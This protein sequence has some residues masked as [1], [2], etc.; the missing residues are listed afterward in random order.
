MSRSML[1]AVAVVS[2]AILAYQVLLM[3]LFSIT[4]WHHFAYMIISVA[5]LG[6]GASGTALALA[7]DRL[8]PHFRAAFVVCCVLF[9]IS[10]IGSFA[11]AVR[12]PF[13]PLAIVWDRSQLLWLG[14]SYALL[15][16][17][18][19][20][21]GSAIGL[22]FARA[23]HQLGRTYAFDLVGAG[24]GALGI[25]G[26]LF[27]LSP[28][29]ALRLVAALGFGAGALACLGARRA[30]AVALTA[31]ALLVALWLPPGLT[32][33]H[34]HVSQYKGLSMALQVPDARII[35]ERSSPLGLLTLVESPTIPFRHAPG[36]SLN[37]L[38]EPPPQL[39]LFT[40]ADSLTVITRFTGDLEPLAYL[41]FTT[42]A[43]PYHLIRE[44]ETLILGAGGGE[45][46]LLALYHGAPR[47]DAVELNPQ[48]I[49]LVAD[50]HADFAGALYT[51]PSVE[52]H[53][54][55]ARSFV[56]RTDEQFD[57]IQMPLLTSF[58]AAA[59]GTQSLH[60]S[61]AYT[62]EAMGEYLD[63]LQPGGLLAITLWLKLPPRDMPKLLAIAVEALREA[64]IEDPGARLALVRGW[65]TS[66]LLVRNGEFTPDE[67]AALR[68]FAEGRSFDLDWVPG[69]APEEA[70]RFN[71]LE[72][73]YF[74]EAALALTGP[75]SGAYI[76]RYKFNIA[77]ATDNRPYFYDFFRWRSLSELVRMGPQ[78]ASTLLDMGYLIL[79]ATL[80]QATLLSLVLILLP[81]VI[82]RRRFGG[83]A[84]KLR[85]S[86]Y[87]LALGLAFLYIEIAFIQRFALFLG[88]PLYAV[89]VVL[90][91]FLVFAG[92]GSA[93][94]GRLGRALISRRPGALGLIVLGIAL[95]ALSYLFLLGPI[96]EVLIALPDWAKIIISLGLIAPLACL[97]GM[98]FPLGLARGARESEDLLPWAWGI[99]GCAS[100][101]ASILATLLAIHFGFTA[102]VSLAVAL[103]LL[104]PLLLGRVG[105]E[106]ALALGPV[107]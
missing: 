106:P 76:E 92:L 99:N 98:P 46:V 53:V 4:G 97:M 35:E 87:F 103:Y 82:R 79:V 60:E 63:R 72:R 71:I 74:Y 57:L 31:A 28:E 89:A 41:D 18:F 24:T 86:A 64:G 10:A 55:E 3:R 95:I 30:P 47:I 81:L 73:P 48:V 107:H 1:L 54:G 50:E 78:G 9:A 105:S 20:F 62:V 58:G 19:F 67:I 102:V 12:L 6:F 38:T 25:V 100:V 26:L 44:P 7:R 52:T 15:V 91:G 43:A 69:M 33:L 14:A 42:T 13:N 101:V 68:D 77:P 66:T 61:Y 2:A 36:L 75:E 16:L 80:V 85:I 29:G 65:K 34:P 56:A 8:L 84:P 23:P 27:W 40:D 83:S 88:H 17:P 59:A 96:F 90:A 45:Q 51:H 49:D 32:A 93:V 21:G 5:L 39:G 70:N 94:S 11:A 22:S 37:N 104:A